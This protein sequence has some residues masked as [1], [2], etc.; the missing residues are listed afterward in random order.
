MNKTLINHIIR[1]QPQLQAVRNYLY[2]PPVDHVLCGF[3]CENA[4]SGLYIWKYAFP[5]FDRAGFLHLSYG[6]RLPMPDGF[7]SRSKK[8][9]RLLAS[10]ICNRIQRHYSAVMA[11]KDLTQFARYLESEVGLGHPLVHLSYAS[12]LVLTGQ[13]DEAM[14]HL[15]IIQQSKA[16]NGMRNLLADV[17]DMVTD[18]ESGEDTAKARI[19]KWEEESRINFDLDR[20]LKVS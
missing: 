19:G 11:L 18:L 16:M 20:A 13:L 6:Q 3:L 12:T 2:A 10:E 5:L 4:P 17:R 8:G 7:L 1:I 14:S 15:T 9:P